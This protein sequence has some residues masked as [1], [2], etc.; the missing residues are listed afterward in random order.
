MFQPSPES[1]IESMQTALAV[2][3]YKRFVDRGIA[4]AYQTE[5]LDLL[6]KGFALGRGNI[7]VYDE[8]FLRLAGLLKNMEP[9][10][11][12]SIVTFATAIGIEEVPGMHPLIERVKR[13]YS[14]ATPEP[15]ATFPAISD[16]ERLE[17]DLN[18]NI[19]DINPQKGDLS[20]QL[21]ELSQLLTGRDVARLQATPEQMLKF[22][23]SI[24]FE[25]RVG[26]VSLGLGVRDT[27]GSFIGES[28]H[29]TGRAGKTV[30]FSKIYPGT[31]FSV[32]L[33]NNPQGGLIAENAD[34]TIPDFPGVPDALKHK[35]SAKIDNIIANL[36]TTIATEVN[37]ITDPRGFEVMG[38]RITGKKLQ[39]DLR[40]KQQ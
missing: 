18:Q 7:D 23:E 21:N 16:A 24:P 30:P 4:L 13:D 40:K 9:D 29:I 2:K 35:V 12:P 15:A 5:D 22:L 38:F 32:D 6:E 27:K 34:Y 17:N 31:D 33:R 14:L 8:T 26:H 36:D 25:A 1:R 19:I 39:L 28:L 20:K 3:N 37:K 11:A 10:I